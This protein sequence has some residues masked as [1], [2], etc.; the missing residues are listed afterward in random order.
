MVTDTGR[1]CAG[2]ING[3]AGESGGGKS[4]VA[5]NLG[6]AQML[7]GAVI[8]HIDG[9]ES[10]E[11]AVHYNVNIGNGVTASTGS[12]GGEVHTGDAWKDAI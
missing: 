6:T 4:W 12:A 5:M 1:E 3:L 8:C 2:R 11:S 10:L 9:E 7:A